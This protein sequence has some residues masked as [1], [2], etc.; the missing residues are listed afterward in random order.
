[1]NGAPDAPAIV[2]RNLTV[3]YGDTVVLKHVSFD[4]NHGEMFAILGGSGCGKSTLLRHMIG[5][6]PPM[7]GDVLIRGRNITTAYGA[8]REQILRD[9][10]VLFQSA[11]LFGS[12]SLADN[13]DLPLI[14]HT[15]LPAEVIATLVTMR[16]NMVGISGRAASMPGELS[17]GQRKRA[18]LA[19]AMAMEP[20][21]LFFDEPSAGLDPVT[22]AALD[23]L[24][25]DLNTSLGLTIV[26]VTHELPSIFAVAHRVIM[27]DST[28]QGI[29]AEGTPQYLRDHADDP[30][31]R[32]FMTR[33]G[34]Q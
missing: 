17:G 1:M 24:I 3:G 5:L 28:A 21:I 2:V 26:I 25:I 13:I 22:S 10:G 14:V 8:E 18:G 15:D 16:L 12:M 34:L 7:S 4:V 20:R 33:G 31:V 6:A 11:A 30:R 19:R 32:Q 23:R 9:I 27:L 29:I